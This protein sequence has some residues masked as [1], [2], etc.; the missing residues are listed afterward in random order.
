MAMFNPARATD[1]EWLLLSES[2]ELELLKNTVE[3]LCDS[4]TNKV[5]QELQASCEWF[6]NKQDDG[7]KAFVGP[8]AQTVC[9]TLTTNLVNDIER[10]ENNDDR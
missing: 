3:R 8:V 7:S 5:T 6:V 1:E 10:K 9:D 2:I 4:D